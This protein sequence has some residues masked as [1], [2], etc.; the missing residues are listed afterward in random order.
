MLASPSH[1]LTAPHVDV[2]VVSSLDD[3]YSKVFS[4]GS[5]LSSFLDGYAVILQIFNCALGLSFLPL[6][7]ICGF[8]ALNCFF[9][10][11][12]FVAALFTHRFIIETK[13]K[14]LEEIEVAMMQR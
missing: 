5:D 14:S 12:C 3:L 13:G 10:I 4:M 8:A 9:A 11:M 7:D 2:P 1:L 6:L